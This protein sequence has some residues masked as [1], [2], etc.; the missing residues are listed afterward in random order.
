[1]TESQELE[2]L[3]HALQDV[4]KWESIIGSPSGAWRTA[5]GSDLEADDNIA[6]P[7]DVSPAAWAAIFAAVS[8]LGCLRDSLF[9]QTGPGAFAAPIHT[10][11]QLTLVRGALEN[12]SMAVW[13]LQPDLS[14]DRIL[15]RVQLDWCELDQLD[16]VRVEMHSPGRKTM[17]QHKQDLTKLLLKAGADPA[18]LKKRPGYGEIVSAA[19]DHGPAG[20]KAALIVWKACS[21]VAHGELRGMIAYLSHESVR[22][23]APGMQLIRVAGNVQLM[24]VGAMMG[25]ETTAR[26]LA[27][28]SMR[29]GTQIAT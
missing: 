25:L 17:A 21:A 9:H 11:G 2:K 28:Y 12:A 29:A 3:W 4:A 20:S 5:P 7:C 1:M 8:H 16:K 14:A 27:A 22:S 13:L 18:K 10:H 24:I 26:A 19:G 15:R 6:H 23:S